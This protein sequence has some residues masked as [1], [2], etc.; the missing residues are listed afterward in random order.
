VTGR[1]V[2]LGSVPLDPV[3]AHGG[4]G[5]ILFNRVF[6]GD[7][8]ASACRFVDYAVVPPGCSIG[9]HRHGDDEEIYVVLEGAGV[10]ML[11]DV[12][13]RVAAGSVIVNAPGGT[14]GLTNDGS[15]PIRIFVVEIA[16]PPGS[17]RARGADA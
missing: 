5:R 14:H 16:A 10:M 13:H 6:Q 8:L 7:Q 11:D 12:P 17:A 9:L 2:D 1:I 3:V 4:E 15:V